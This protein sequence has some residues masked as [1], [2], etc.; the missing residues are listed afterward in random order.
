MKILLVH[1]SYQQPGGEDVVVRSEQ[2]LLSAAGHQVSTYFRHNAEFDQTRLLARVAIGS[3]TIWARDSYRQVRALLERE[4]PNV[5][6]FHNIFP[7]IS[8]SAYYACFEAQV[9]VVQTVHNYR[10]ICPSATFFRDGGIC[11]ECVER[12]LWQGVKH[13]CYR[14]SRA[15]TAVL[16]LSLALHRKWGTWKQMI[17]CYI[18]PTDFVRRKFISVGVN[19][20]KVLVKPNFA[21]PDPGE[22]E[23]A[24]DYAVF[25]GRLTVD[26]GLRTLIKAWSKLERRIP[27]VVVGDGPLRAELEA[28]VTR[29]GMSHVRF[30][31]SLPHAKTME[32]LKSARFLVFPSEWYETFGLTIV[33]AFA[34]GIPVICSRL[35]AMQE[36]VT[37]NCT[38]LH[39]APGDS[40]DLAAKVD[41]AWTHPAE[42][43]TLGRAARLEYMTKY[44]S[45]QNYRIL[46]A[47]YDSAMGRPSESTEVLGA[48]WAE[49]SS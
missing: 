39:F 25:A 43:Q 19:P 27:L 20:E 31:G 18:T 45:K 5:A 15:T 33:E 22:R 35:G 34:C 6:H 47:A 13:G 49:T 32:A 36:L 21:D 37:D 10:L 4:K 44:T 26:K 16:A 48:T 14:N 3:K 28:T 23:G 40:D 46:M 12:S 17:G 41:W 42:L 8:P 9:P 29:L 38:G 11:E 30:E 7:L 2:T 24:G 1:N